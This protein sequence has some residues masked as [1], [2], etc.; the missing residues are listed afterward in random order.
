MDT[1]QD[2]TFF[3]LINKYEYYNEQYK[4]KKFYLKYLI[5]EL[6]AVTFFELEPLIRA[7]FFH[8]F[9]TYIGNNSPKCYIQVQI[10]HTSLLHDITI[11]FI[12]LEE[13]TIY[14]LINMF[15]L[16]YQSRTPG[17]FK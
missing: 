3:T 7:F 15:S 4:I 12:K 5:D 6:H 16:V 14:H 10:K 17:N 8:V 9:D 2:D 11:D 1:Y 13:L